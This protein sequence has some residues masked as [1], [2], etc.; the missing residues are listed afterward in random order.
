MF[1]LGFILVLNVLI[2]IP[3]KFFPLS[4]DQQTPIVFADM[5][6]IL[7]VWHATCG[8]TKT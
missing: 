3:C 4:D 1:I 2:V 5:S 6:V 7:L 8:D